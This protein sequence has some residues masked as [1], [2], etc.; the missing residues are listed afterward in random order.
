MEINIIVLIILFVGYYAVKK[1]VNYS[2]VILIEFFMMLA[3]YNHKTLEFEVKQFVFIL[4][5]F[6]LSSF[7]TSLTT[8]VVKGTWI[9]PDIKLPLDN[10]QV[11]TG[12]WEE[13]LW[14]NVLLAVMIQSVAF[15]SNDS[16][17][18]L[19][20]VSVTTLFFVVFHRYHSISDYIEMYVFSLCLAVC[21]LYVPYLNIGLHI[22]RNCFILKLQENKKRE[23]MEKNVYFQ[24]QSG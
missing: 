6:F 4:V 10:L 7:L 22:G 2:L 23:E 21:V 3:Y 9:K 18:L 15:F 5:G 12:I 8:L 16:L 17:N 14:R 24:S 11:I 19:V 20:A 13:I 1:Y